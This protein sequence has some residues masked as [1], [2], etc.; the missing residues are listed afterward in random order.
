MKVTKFTLTLIYILKSSFFLL[1]QKNKITKKSA[2]L[3]EVEMHLPL[4]EVVETWCAPQA[5]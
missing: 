4:A 3:A 1:I 2:W 5:A